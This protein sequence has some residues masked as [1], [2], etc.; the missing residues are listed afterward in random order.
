MMI[1]K[2]SLL[3]AALL[4]ALS[5]LALSPAA[6]AGTEPT[7]PPAGDV[8]ALYDT[9]PCDPNG[10]TS[11]DATLA[12]QLKST[13]TGKL[14]GAM[15]A[16]RVS[17]ARMVIKAVRDRGMPERAAV[18]AI[19]TTIVESTIQNVADEV[20]HDSLGLFQQRASWGSQAQRLDPIWA[21]NAFLNKMVKEY[22]NNSWQSAPIGEVCQAVQ[23]SAYPDRYQYEASDAAKIVKALW[24][25]RYGADF[26]GNGVGDI[27]ATADGTLHVWNG[28]GGNN[29]ETRVEVGP[30]WAPFSR[31][32]AGDF[33][34]DGKSDLAAVKDGST[35][36]VW[37]GKGGN[38]FGGA[39][40]LGPGWG[41]YAGTLTS[42]GDVNGDGRDD[43]AAVGNG[44]LYV[45]NGN[46]SNGFGNAVEIGPG[47]GSF[48]KPVGGDFDGDGIGDLAAVKDGSTLHIWNGK[49]ANNF[50]A[51]IAI[52]P[53]WAPFAGS[54]M[55]LGDVNRDGHGDIAAVNNGTLYLW[56]GN[57]NNGFGNA[58]EIGPGWAPYV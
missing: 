9:A 19:T 13:L 44:T 58:I 40:A 11:R 42:V 7:E 57:G 25:P 48:S 6:T 55:S 22:P 21:T 14:A 53:G 4:T 24:A 28:K 17:C 51:A 43:I 30:G 18:I 49:G 23:V 34:G 47:W 52:G 12:T 15:T 29:F 39:V 33:N 2:K 54:L 10:T 56:N 45:W 32:I 35:L 5:V 31:P 3:A 46:G 36:H 27:F 16:Y 20:D 37:N 41:P 50:S 1:S 26:D 8:R 38:S